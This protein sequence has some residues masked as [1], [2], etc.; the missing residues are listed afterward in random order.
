MRLARFGRSLSPE[1]VD[2]QAWGPGEVALYLR[3]L[4]RVNRYLGG[5]SALLR[6]LTRLIEA[7]FPD[8]SSPFTVLD[9]GTGGGD[10]P[11]ALCAWARKRGRRLRV[12][13]LDRQK[14]ILRWAQEG[15]RGFGEITF[16]GGDARCLPC[17]GRAF[18]YVTASLLLHHFSWEEAA[19][20]LRNFT[21]S[22]RLAVLINDLRRALIP[23]LVILLM[24]RLGTRSRLSRHD[25]PLS[26]L[27][28]F[29]VEEM[30][31]L[32]RAAG[33]GAWRLERAF[34]YRLVLVLRCG[35]RV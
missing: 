2:V 10:L 16:M 17:S 21:S 34:P 12:I 31:G 33:L 28:A 1:L 7:D 19:A 13:G 14:E 15:S 35:E 27:R 5:A 22:A 20:I 26:V 8:P 24:T 4:A 6:P 11:R 18:D 30:E 25:A 3:D 32:A 23:Y 29:T 9:V